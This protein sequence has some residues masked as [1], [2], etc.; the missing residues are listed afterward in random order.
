MARPR[1]ARALG[2]EF[3]YN[4]KTMCYVEVTPAGQVAFGLDDGTYQ[5]VRDGQSALYAVWPGQ[6][7]S[8]L[9][10]IDDIEEFARAR[11]LVHDERRTGLADHEHEVRWAISPFETKPDGVYVS[12]DVHLA[13]GCTIED[14]RTFAKQMRAQRG[15]DV[16]TSTGWGSSGLDP[17]H[18]T[19][20]FSVRRR[21]LGT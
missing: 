8:D 13:C 15:W 16:A 5:R 18:L 10:V 20:S 6:W 17:A 21:S 12:V 4:L 19:Y 1:S 2:D 11:G 9:F 7:S 3:P 14:V